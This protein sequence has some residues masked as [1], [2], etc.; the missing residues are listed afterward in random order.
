[1][2]ILLC[3]FLSI[4]SA[5]RVVCYFIHYSSLRGTAAYAAVPFWVYGKGCAYMDSRLLK[6][7]RKQKRFDLLRSAHTLI[8][9]CPALPN[10][11]ECFKMVSK[12]DFSSASFIALV[13]HNTVINDLHVSTF[14][15][16]RKEMMLLHKLASEGRLKD[17]TL[18]MFSQ[19]L[20]GADDS[21]SRLIKNVCNKFG[22]HVMVKK[23]H[24]KIMLFDTDDGKYVLETSSN[25]N[26]NPK[27][28]FYSIEK[29][30]DVY[31]FYL[32]EI[33]DD[34]QGVDLC[35]L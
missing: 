25:L 30:S 9:Q 1:M 18:V 6:L 32:R 11:D 12:G 19:M 34:G 7:K 21:T 28:E 17:C 31:D 2:F 15:V 3:G 13:A 4:C 24:S 29:D 26:E 33:F 5:V 35:A 10:D 14:R 8:D 16:G 22:W 23:N 27:V 20:D